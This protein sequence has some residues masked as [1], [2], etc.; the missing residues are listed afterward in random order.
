MQTENDRQAIDDLLDFWFAE[1][2]KARWY[3]STDGF[4]ENCRQCFGDLARRAA[5]DE[6][7]HWEET[8]KGALALCLLLDQMPRNIY[9]GTPKAFATDTKATALSE[10]AI[11]R[12]FDRELDL[13]RRKFLYLPFMHSEALADQERSVAISEALN[14]ENALHWAN[15]H[16]D[17]IRR[18]GRFPHRNAVLGRKSTPEEEAF[19]ADGAKSYG[20]SATDK[21]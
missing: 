7:S 16:A 8:A 11:E 21:A 4:D 19:L 13:E 20:Q 5:D 14:D 3:A 1:E 6:L 12:G 18:F 9:R 2:T 17:I 15:D 10:R